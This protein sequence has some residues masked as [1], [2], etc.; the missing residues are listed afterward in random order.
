MHAG[1]GKVAEGKIV[2]LQEWMGKLDA[3]AIQ[4][5]TRL[6]CITMLEVPPVQGTGLGSSGSGWESESKS[7]PGQ[8]SGS[9]SE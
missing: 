3:S 2:M 9:E 4:V 1:K 6:S 8:E 5:Q 7:E